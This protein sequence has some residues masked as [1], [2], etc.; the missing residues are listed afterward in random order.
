MIAILI[1]SAGLRMVLA[2]RGGQGYWTDEMRYGAAVSAWNNW[3]AGRWR[4]GVEYIIGS[5]DHLGF[6]VLM[7][8]PAWLEVHANA[9]IRLLSAI[10]G[11]FSVAN[12]FWVW[13]LARRLGA[14]EREAAW[15]ALAMACSNSLFYWARH[16]MPYDASLFWG[17]ACAWVAFR[18]SP[19]VRDSL[20]AG[21]LGFLA[22]VTYNGYWA[23]VACVL[24][25]HVLMA[26]SRGGELVK[27]AVLGLVGL[28]GSFFLLL[29]VARCLGIYLLPSYLEFARTINQGNYD[30]G[31]VVVF[32]YLWRTE[33]LTA[34]I[35]LGALVAFGWLIRSSRGADRR[36]GATWVFLILAL[37]GILIVGSNVLSRFVV[38]G[39]LVRQVVPF[40]ALLVGWTADRLFDGAADRRAG[41]PHD[42]RQ[43]EWAAAILLLAGAAW[44]MATP[45]AM[46]F[47]A[48]FYP[49]AQRVLAAYKAAHLADGPA[50]LAPGK[51]RILYDGFIWPYPD[52][53][54]LP[55]H[56][57]VLLAIPNPLAWRPYLYEGFNRAQRERIEATDIRMRLVLLQD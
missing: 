48:D 52:E 19:R 38:Y 36:R 16:F 27:R 34:L 11:L 46:V 15:A 28:G 9:N 44:S 49:R 56:F 25:A 6:K 31:Y 2:A 51:F 1:V 40:C 22:F 26:R 29:V 10:V 37:I 42:W 23:L 32:D 24:V 30:D 55:A 54:P 7:L 47:P 35:W 12:I 8:G 17:L 5:A 18:P 3:S 43:G 41:S 45:L 53:K 50:A 14:G 39:R 4:A 20:L 57:R 13:C 33:G 21:F